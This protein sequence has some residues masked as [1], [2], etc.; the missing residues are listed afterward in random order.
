MD[1]FEIYSS[2]YYNVYQQK[3]EKVRNA[4]RNVQENY[5]ASNAGNSF[6]YIMNIS[7]V[8]VDRIQIHAIS[9]DGNFA[10]VD[11]PFVSGKKAYIIYKDND[12]VTILDF[13]H[14]D[15]NP[16]DFQRIADEINNPD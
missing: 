2:P 1:P 9:L 8:D 10:T 14:L 7:F 3:L 15:Y 11:I 12:E 5:R 13:S 4:F 6:E 16:K